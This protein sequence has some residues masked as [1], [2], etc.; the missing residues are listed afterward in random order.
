MF[1]SIETYFETTS[2]LAHGYCLTWR[3][4][5]IALHAV[6]DAVIA[7]SYFIIPVAIFYFVARRRDLAHKGIFWLFA[8]FILACATTH[9]IGLITLWNP[10]YGVEGIVKA[11]TASVSA[12]TVVAAW[13]VIPKA[14][15]L[16]SPSMLREANLRLIEEVDDHSRTNRELSEIRAE[17]ELRV[18]ARTREL[19]AKAAEL[20]TA[21][22]GLRQFAHIA[23]HDLQE[24]LR[25]IASYVDL[26][27]HAN[28][29][30]DTA[31]AARSMERLGIMSRRALALIADVLRFSRLNDY[32]PTRERIQLRG[33]INDV[34]ELFDQQIETRGGTLD[35]DV[36][37]Q[38]VEADPLLVQQIFQNILS[39]AV[40]YVPEFRVPRIQISSRE[41][42]GSLRI[43]IQD[44]G[45][46]F[47]PAL[48]PKIFEPFTRLHG[49]N[50]ADGSGIG[51]AIV[52][53]AAQRLGWP[54]DVETE[55]GTGTRFTLDIP[56]RDLT[57]LHD[58][59]G[60]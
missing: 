1:G 2:F 19:E 53:R 56:L 9:L 18:A 45:I 28:A 24:P 20:E 26:L 44:N 7:L 6:S 8:A 38:T 13:V 21:N 12:L 4:D 36:E 43:T 14:L 51:L 15:L 10:I 17:L 59:P 11:A 50:V 57:P 42:D 34:A 37:E 22:E 33:A 16:P 27:E 5:L 25:K 60:A 35:I 47:E 39:N 58:A 49:R 31:E 23:A 41:L 48:K 30:N 55:E 3:S 52:A 46:G 29:E 40:K 32:T 54:I